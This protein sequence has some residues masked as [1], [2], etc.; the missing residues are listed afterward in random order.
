MANHGYNKPS[1]GT[2]DWH[3]PLNE[4]FKQ[5]ERDIEIRDVAANMGDY[6]PDMGAKFL[7]TDTG[8]TYVGDG[9]NWNLVGYVTRTVGGDLGH[10]VEYED[11]LSDATVNTFLFGSGEELSVFRASFPMKGVSA[12][13]TDSDLTL[14]VYEGGTGGTLLLELDGNEFRDAE[15]DAAGPWVASSSPVT[16]TVSNR[17][18]GPA[19]VVPK[20]WANVRR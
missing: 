18:G 5:L 2:L 6:Q 20:V 13:S 14:R 10:Y 17:S 3:I 11:G 9:S 1:T 7:S 8:A 12:G 4:N 16:V 19:E 15:S